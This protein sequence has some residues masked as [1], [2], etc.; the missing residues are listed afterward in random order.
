MPCRQTATPTS[1]ELAVGSFATEADCLNA[2]KEGAC[3]EGTTCSVQPACQC[4]G[5]GK[6]FKGV[7]TVC[8][9]NPCFPDF[10]KTSC[11]PDPEHPW[12]LYMTISDW[13]GPTPAR[14]NIN[15]TRQ[16]ARSTIYAGTATC[17]AYDFGLLEIG[18]RCPT[19]FGGQPIDG[20][21]LSA[22]FLSG[23]NNARFFANYKD[24]GGN[25]HRYDIR[26]ALTANG[27]ERSRLCQKDFPFTGTVS[28]GGVSFS[29]RI[30]ENSLP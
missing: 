9:P 22:M 19:P 30:E 23:G 2:C 5:A 17:W 15:S 7:G 26:W 4:Q 27:S 21:F 20:W 25:C 13:T 3:C 14:F 6:T 24:A 10:C 29:Y 18:D 16:I 12:F 28:S 11:S 1:D 8:S